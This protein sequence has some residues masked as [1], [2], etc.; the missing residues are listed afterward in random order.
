[1]SIREAL[2]SKNLKNIVAESWSMSWPMTA[3]MF[4]TFIIGLVDVYVAGKFGKEIQAAYGIAF[5]VYF[6]FSIIGAALTIGSISIIARLFTS[7]KKEDCS[8]TIDTSVAAVG[9]IGLIMSIIGVASAPLLV[10]LLQVPEVLKQPAEILLRFYNAG[11]LFNYVLIN[12]N[13]ILRA[14]KKMRNSLVT[15]IVVCVANTVLIFFFAFKMPFGFKGIALATVISTLLGCLLNSVYLRRLV[16]FPLRFS[17]RALKAIT[18]IGWP[19]GVLQVVW[20]VGSMLLFVI[21]GMLPDHAVEIMAAFTNGLRI[22]SVIFLPA[23]AFNMANAVV[24]GNLLGK[25]ET[26]DAFH[27]GIITTLI[28]VGIVTVLTLLVMLKAR[29]VA[30]WL[31]NNDVVVRESIRYIYISL[32]SEPFMAWGVILGGGLNGAGDTKSVMN[33]VLISVWLVKLPLSYLFGILFG[34]GAMAFWWVM[35][36]AMVV[37]AVLIGRRYF[38]KRWIIPSQVIP[39]D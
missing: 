14:C 26:E 16:S 1:M 25:G 5:Q 13:G 30:G 15:M 17:W 35:N 6:I 32:I 24:V 31:S 33:S 38:K 8:S 27:S 37:Q 3:I 23:F 4:C 29:T 10:R 12:S 21:I 19:A 22:E 18:V 34:G 9:M 7:D 11:T 28:G 39:A 20:Q 2:Y 36:L